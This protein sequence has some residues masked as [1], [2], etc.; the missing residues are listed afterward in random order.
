MYPA[1]QSP[2]AEAALLTGDDQ[3]RVLRLSDPIRFR[4]TVAPESQKEFRGQRSFPKGSYWVAWDGVT[5]AVLWEQNSDEAVS[6]AAGRVVV[7]VL[8]EAVRKAGGVVQIQSCSPGCQNLFTHTDAL[9][10]PQGAKHAKSGP[11]LNVVHADSLSD[12]AAEL[13]RWYGHIGYAFFL[14]TLYKNHARRI[15][16]L[17]D[18]SGHRLSALLLVQQRRAAL[19]GLGR[20]ER[21][22]SRFAM[23]GWRKDVERQMADVWLASAG[24]EVMRRDWDEERRRF[25]GYIDGKPLAALFASDFSDD[26]AAIDS[27]DLTLARD[28]LSHSSGRLDTRTLALVTALAGAAGLLGAAVGAVVAG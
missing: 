5:L 18:L 4:L 10:V 7:D 8:R 17:V 21:L 27:I 20:I 2:E 13:G 14:F 3:F 15:R 9:L 16:D 26:E 23:R 22:K 6:R 11:G 24:I 28:A 19:S 1:V 12:P 25:K